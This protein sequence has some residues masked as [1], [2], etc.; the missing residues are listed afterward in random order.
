MNKEPD[1]I[2]SSHEFKVLN[3]SRGWHSVGSGRTNEPSVEDWLK[4]ADP[5]VAENLPESGIV[6][7]L[8]FLTSGC[9]MIARSLDTYHLLRDAFSGVQVRKRYWAL[10]EAQAELPSRGHFDLCFQSRYKR[11]KKISVSRFGP[12]EQRG[13]CSWRQIGG[14]LKVGPKNARLLE[15][16]LIGP[17]RRHQIRAGFAFFDAPIIGDPL[18]GLPL[19]SKREALNQQDEKLEFFGLHASRLDLPATLLGSPQDLCFLASAPE[20]WPAFSTPD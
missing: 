8:D 3:K 13:Q 11:S 9:L 17:G 16:E 14:L 5:E 7:R 1:V 10:V 20:D 2:Y 18:Y 12:N 6:H 15:V 19:Q 4:T